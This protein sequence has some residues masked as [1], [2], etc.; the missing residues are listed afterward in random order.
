MYKKLVFS[1][2]NTTRLTQNNSKFFFK[3]IRNFFNKP[4]TLEDDA[5]IVANLKSR[6]EYNYP[7]DYLDHQSYFP[8]TLEGDK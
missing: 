1:N 2:T 6:S 3:R 5:K 7:I 4:N 8:T